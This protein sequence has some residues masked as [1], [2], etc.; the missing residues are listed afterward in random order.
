MKDHS[1]CIRGFFWTGKA[2]YAKTAGDKDIVFG[3]YSV[4]EGGTSGE[5]QVVWHDIGGKEVPRLECFNDAWS[6]L[7]LFTDLITAL[8]KLDDQNITQQQFVDVLLEC[9]FTDLTKYERP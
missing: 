6:A 7:S 4:D 8:G 3:M 1:G 5:M 2:W 9:G